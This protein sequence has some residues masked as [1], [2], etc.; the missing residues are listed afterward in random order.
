MLTQLDNYHRL[1]MAISEQ[2]IPWLWQII[3][4]ALRNGASVREIVNKLKDALEGAYCPR[5]YG[6]NDLDIA[7]LVFRLGGH[8]LLFALN[9]C[10]G[11]PSIHT[12]RT[13]SVFTKLTPTIGPIRNKQL[14]ENIDSIVLR[15]H[16]DITI[17]RSVSLMVDE[18]ALEEMAVHF[19]KYNKIAGLCWKHSHL[20]DPVLCTYKSAV[21]I[22]QKIHDGEV[23]LGKELT[24][25]RA[26]CF[27][28]D[29]LYPILAAPTCKTEDAADMEGVLVRAIERWAATG[30]AASVGPV[31]S[32]ATD[33][34]ATH[35]AAGHKLFLK[36]PLLSESHLY[37][38][39]SNMPGLNTMTGDA[40]VT[41]DFDFKHIF[42][43]KF[44]IL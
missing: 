39:L 40:E 27:G 36:K 5:G 31:W 7:T 41:L 22:T 43:C 21:T 42:K 3:N 8:Q 38:I 35:R 24:V 9:Q 33:G 20:V 15:T 34:D 25:I 2:D 1:L 16:T 29:E 14:D 4:V 26:A 12:L 6:A 44:F 19:S 18:I 10:L 23:H 32:F 28:E 37:G 30:A 11:L 17:L 13:K